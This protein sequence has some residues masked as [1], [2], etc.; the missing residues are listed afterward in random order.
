[1]KIKSI[2]GENFRLL[3]KKSQN[4]IILDDKNTIIV[5]RNNCGKTSFIELVKCFTTN[6]N[7]NFDFADFSISSISNFN[8]SYKIYKKYKKLKE[9]NNEENAEKIGDL[10]KEFENK[11]PIIKLEIV[12]TYADDDNTAHLEPFITELKSDNKEVILQYEYYCEK[13]DRLFNRY[14]RLHGDSKTE[15]LEYIKDNYSTFYNTRIWTIDSTNR[16]NRNQIDKKETWKTDLNKLLKTAFIF[17]RRELDDKAEDKSKELSKL[18]D[19]YFKLMQ[20][21]DEKLLIELTDMLGTASNSWDKKYPDI[22][23]EYFDDLTTFGYPGLED[24]NIELKSKFSPD[25][26]LKN[27]TDIFYSSNSGYSLPEAYNG[28]GFS[29]L[30]YIIL[31]LLYFYKEF[32]I[33]GS[34]LQMIFIEEPEVHLHP[35]MQK[36]FIR[37][38]VDFINKKFDKEKG[39]LKWNV[40]IVI[41]THSSHIIS[42]S[43]YRHIRYL[44]KRADHVETKDLE[45]F[46]IRKPD[47]IQFLEQYLKLDKSDMFF[48]DKVI[49]IEGTVERML[50]PMMNK[51]LSNDDKEL[52]LSSQYISIIEVGGAYAYKFKE[53]LSFIEVKTLIITDLDCVDPNNKYSKIAPEL[54]KEYTSSN[55]TLQD[56]LPKLKNIDELMEC[57]EDNKIDC[58]ELFRVAYQYQYPLDLQNCEV[59]CGR[60]FEEQFVLENFDII[61]EKISKF[62]SIKTPAGNLKGA[63]NDII[64]K[65]KEELVI[66]NEVIDKIVNS[67]SNK[68][69]FAFD[70][71]LHLELDD[72]E[73]PTYIREGLE[74]LQK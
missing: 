3:V 74:W 30:I 40:Q 42:E 58:N 67:I 59:L 25:S 43:S 32:Q 28:L 20:D 54:K 69:T 62:E 6:N 19:S 41:T 18:F 8:S 68:P 22:F 70:I 9:K 15:L 36:T 47:G 11:M 35:Q 65:N 17:A 56:W 46:A 12:I 5:G 48:A 1:M 27:N 33:E 55:L 53:L 71:M 10:K 49:M 72:W 38:I 29:N 2:A 73:V 44:K 21:D 52:S 7:P 66:N 60:S 57:G 63:I 39:A 23:K 61:Y 13:A 45:D 16:E 4:R 37:N 24:R 14:E 34:R 50:L 64:S 26:I 51:K 31:K